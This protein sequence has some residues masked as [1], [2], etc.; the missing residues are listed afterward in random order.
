MLNLIP[1]LG[2]VYV[3]RFSEAGRSFIIN[4]TLIA[5]SAYSFSKGD[6]GFGV[7]FSTIGLIT[8]TANIYGGVNASIQRNSIEGLM[9]SKKMLELIPIPGPGPVLMRRE[10]FGE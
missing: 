7:A 9:N 8:Y 10:I 3:G 2:Y 5:L 6:T 4:S 1:G